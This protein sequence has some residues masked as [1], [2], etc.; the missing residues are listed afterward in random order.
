MHLLPP[1]LLLFCHLALSTGSPSPPLL[2]SD[3]AISLAPRNTLFFRQLTDLQTFD[4]ALGGVRASSI[5]NSGVPD[6]PFAVDGNYFS[7]FQSAA[8]RSCDEQFQGCQ[9]L[10]NGQGQDGQGKGKGKGKGKGGAGPLTVDMCN[11]QKEKCTAAQQQAR[12][13]DFKTGVPSTNI[14]P[15][16]LFSDF[17]LICER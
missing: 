14:G 9:L 8:Q 2:T 13:Q 1:S 4:A 15:D 11:Q 7:D 17:D 5:T 6:R 12:V 3:Y 10:A 16:P